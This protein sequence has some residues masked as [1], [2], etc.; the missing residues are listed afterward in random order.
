MA[1]EEAQAALAWE[2]RLPEPRPPSQRSRLP[3]EQRTVRLPV[4]LAPQEARRLD[5]P[6]G[7][8][9]RRAPATAAPRTGPQDRVALSLPAGAGAPPRAST[10]HP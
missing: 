8:R 7:D 1:W 6:R 2:G 4:L 5:E 9:P 3:D 10:I